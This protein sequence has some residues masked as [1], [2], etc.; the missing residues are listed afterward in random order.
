ME[1]PDLP[2]WFCN[3]CWMMY[4]AKWDYDGWAEQYW[5]VLV[6]FEPLAAKWLDSSRGSECRNHVINEALKLYTVF[7]DWEILETPDGAAKKLKHLVKRFRGLVGKKES[8]E[9][10]VD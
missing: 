5:G 1:N 3:F 10:H 8:Q 7:C 9:G 4:S 6:L 2:V